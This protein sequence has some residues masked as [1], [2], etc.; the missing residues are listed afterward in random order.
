MSR[1]D[2]I[3][4][5]IAK[6]FYQ[7]F[8]SGE[9]LLLF[10]SRANNTHHKHSD[11]DL[12]ISSDCQIDSYKLLKFKDFVDDFPTLYGIDIVDISVANSQLKEQIKKNNI[13]L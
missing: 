2:Y 12:A 8:K 3:I 6:E 13:K 11:I 7:I 5:T 1:I 4:T 10:G 9:S